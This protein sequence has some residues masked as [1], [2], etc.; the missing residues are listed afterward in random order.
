MRSGDWR[1]ISQGLNLR[2]QSPAFTVLSK[3]QTFLNEALFQSDA[4][5]SAQLLNDFAV[6]LDKVLDYVVAHDLGQA[7]CLGAR[8]HETALLAE[9]LTRTAAM[10]S[11]QSPEQDLGPTTHDT[12]RTLDPPK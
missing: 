1:T 4:R 11:Y 7:F 10:Q 5:S 2:Q 6:P 12:V 9:Q 8:E 3:K